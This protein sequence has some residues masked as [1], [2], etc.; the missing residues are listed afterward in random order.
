MPALLRPLA[1]VLLVFW[2]TGVLAQQPAWLQIE[3]RP[4]AAQGI[5][6]ARGYARRIENVAGFRLGRSSWHAVVI[7]PLPSV[8]AARRLR[9]ELRRSGL[10]PADSFVTDGSS[11]SDRFWPIEG[12]PDAAAVQEM[13]AG[14]ETPAAPPAPPA[15]T[16]TRDAASADAPEAPVET[17]EQARRSERTLDEAA[18]R[19]LQVALRW[20]GF[21][22]GPIDGDF[23]PGTRGAMRAWQ[24]AEGVDATGVLTTAQRGALRAA[25]AALLE[26]LG[27]ETIT[28]AQAGIA[29]RMPAGLVAFDRYQ[30]PFAH[31]EPVGEDAPHKVLLISRRGDRTT[32]G[33]LYNIMQ[34]LRIV[35]ETGARSLSPDSFSII[36]EGDEVVSRTEVWLRDGIIKG[37]TLVW[38][39]GDAARRSRVEDA[40]IDSFE[41]LPGVLEAVDATE[42]TPRGVDLLAGLELRRPARV[43][44]GVHV[45]ADGTVL[46]A[47]RDLQS[48]GRITLG[49]EIEAELLDAGGGSGGEAGDGAED[50][51]GLALLRPV[52]RTVPR[53]HAALA[54]TVPLAGSP[55]LLSGYSFGGALGAPSLTAGT[56]EQASGLEGEEGMLRLDLPARPGDAGGPLLD[57]SGAMIGVL[58]PQPDGARSLPKG[59]AL[60][61]DAATIRAVLARNEIATAPAP[62][63]RPRRA[64]LTRRAA[65][66]TV[67][68]SCWN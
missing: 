37:F 12:A 53:G 11:F 2:G 8:D 32:L 19:R 66:M 23:G 17:L 20:A 68:V 67:L 21:Y 60:A 42:D 49:D 25:Q 3:A 7:G 38:P 22:D 47:A 54:A 26:E 61:A 56:L 63:D 24:E 6:A 52:A 35:P 14:P 9:G 29:V 10:I 34:T 41:M 48:C 57:P 5:D 62:Q 59:V 33:G 18:R 45:D 44:S 64:E 51:G 65:K 55:V 46:T 27:L 39:A 4:G 43:Q 50:G 31:Y 13:Q 15:Q 40:M 58:L 1:F 36:G 16:A 28:D 30:P